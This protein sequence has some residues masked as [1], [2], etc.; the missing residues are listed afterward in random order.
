LETIEAIHGGSARI[1]SGVRSL[2]ECGFD[3]GCQRIIRDVV[4]TR[5]TWRRHFPRSKL[6]QHLFPDRRVISGMIDVGCI[7][8]EPRRP[9][10]CVVA[11]NAEP[12]EHRP[13]RGWRWK[14]R[15]RLRAGCLE[16]GTSRAQNGTANREQNG[17][18]NQQCLPHTLLTPSSDPAAGS[19]SHHQRDHPHHTAHIDTRR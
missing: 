11:G 4:G 6:M 10:R 18:A 9:K 12:I 2:I 17:H 1:G 7:Q 3:V 15:W 8:L 14:R 19:K 13:P 5:R 16:T